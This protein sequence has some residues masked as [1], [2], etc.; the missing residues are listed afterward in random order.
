LLSALCSLLSAG[1]LL[2]HADDEPFTEPSNWGGT[3]LMEI[4]SARVL[5]ENRY[6][7]GASQI[8]PYRYYYIAVSPFKGLEID[9]RVTELMG[10]PSGLG[11]AYGNDKDKAIDFKYQ[12][13]KEGKYSPAISLGIMDPH[14][15]RKYASQYLVA[16]KQIYPFDFTLG[17]GNG[18]FGK[19]PLPSQGEGF[20]IEMFSDTK[21]WLKDSQFF[22][23]IQFAPSEKIALMMEYNPIKYET[24]NVVGE[25]PVSSRFNY[26][27]RI[28]PWKWS[29]IDLSYQRGN[30]VGINLS[31]AFDIGQPLIPIYDHPYREKQEDRTSP[32]HK[33]LIKALHGSGFSNI[34]I[35]IQGYD[36]WIE[37]Q[38]DTY[39]YSTKAIG[40]ILKIVNEIA[41]LIPRNAEQKIHIVLTDNLIPVIQ[42][43]TTRLDIME[44]YREKLTF[45]EFF[46][47]SK[48]NTDVLEKPDV[49]REHRKY[50]DYGVKPAFR[51]FLNDPSGFFK[52]RLG[53]YLWGSYSPW[54]GGSF[55][56][57]LEGFPLN[58]VSTSNEP[59][60]EP[61]RTDI[62]PYQKKGV[63]LGRLMYNQIFKTSHE[64]YG[65]FAAGL[66]EIQ[67]AGLDGEVAIPLRNGR[68]M[69]GLSS[70]VVK[71]RDVDN[72]FKLSNE[73][74]KTYTTAFLNTRLNIPEYEF[75]VNLKT[76]RFLAGD[77][78]SRL[79]VSKFIKG[80]VI[81][82]WYSWTD[83]SIFKDQFNRG[84]H[85]K[86]VMLT[87]PLRLFKG[88]DSKT[89]YSYAISPWTRDVAQDIDH[90]NNLFDFMGRNTKIYLDRDKKE[91]Y[92]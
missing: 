19:R 7:V 28:K 24:L 10:V 70:S 39:Y 77:K 35:D 22:W 56:G 44:F 13:I 15:T 87:F 11:S 30:Q 48:I 12:F 83:T 32:L 33:R 60:S 43:T 63:S 59:L 2:V 91:L 46:Y 79:T 80:V 31:V 1:L 53:V 16:S 74:T 21:G 26:G 82:A 62:V 65:K 69:V 85:D 78:G 5:K 18:R 47:L 86:G 49:K 3:G 52:Y 9:G 72:A 23:G 51:M 42:L 37:A 75:S 90:Y 61:I 55:I 25:I 57:G 20:K 8:D 81:S 89:T 6:R 4:P 66:L 76:G 14:G 40:V 88:S 54:E 58:T 36:L 64:L 17:F 27:L 84:Y 29:D 41:P 67:Y 50:F 68:F 71:K 92:R 38:N 73:Y 34:G 45:N